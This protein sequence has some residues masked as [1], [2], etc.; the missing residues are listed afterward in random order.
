MQRP[1]RACFFVLSFVS[2]AKSSVNRTYLR[3]VLDNHIFCHFYDF[4][5]F[6]NRLGCQNPKHN[7]FDSCRT[8][9]RTIPASIW[10]W[11]MPLINIVNSQWTNVF[12]FGSKQQIETCGS[13]EQVGKYSFNWRY[14]S[15]M[16][17][18]I[19][20]FLV[21]HWQELISFFVETKMLNNVAPHVEENQ[22][23]VHIVSKWQLIFSPIN[24]SAALGGSPVSNLLLTV[25]N[26]CLGLITKPS[27]VM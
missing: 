7:T 12:D 22:S 2:I 25:T 24:F 8:S 9:C 19:Q 16:T 13:V 21:L 5:Y 26:C 1:L 3:W 20:Q 15:N 4:C 27:R 23:H 17:I 14:S 18:L 10:M 11:T 6:F